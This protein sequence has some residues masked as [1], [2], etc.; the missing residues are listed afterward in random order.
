MAKYSAVQAPIFAIFDPGLYDE[1]RYEWK[2]TN[3]LYLLGLIFVIVLML[4]ISWWYQLNMVVSKEATKII[5]QL[6][7]MTF[8]DGEMSIDKPSPYT[9]SNPWPTSKDEDMSL[10]VFD[11][12]GKYSS[13]EDAKTA[14]LFTKK[15]M[16]PAKDGK[17]TVYGDIGSNGKLDADTIS[18]M[19]KMFVIWVPILVVLLGLPFLW[20]LHALQALIYAGVA[21]VVGQMSGSPMPFDAAL[22]LAIIAMSPVM[23][24]STGMSCTNTFV[25]FW[26]FI[27]IPIVIGYIVFAVR[28]TAK[29]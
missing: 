13:P 14:V 4:A 17:R 29:T 8:Q 16:I 21:A 18:G 6:P 15:E 2:G 3:L 28:T 19:V 9:I 11:M 26:G 27:T 5:A 23:L 10:A 20:S 12:D 25:P 22:R 7:V 1:V 24:L